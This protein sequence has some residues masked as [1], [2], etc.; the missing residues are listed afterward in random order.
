MKI[1][2]DQAHLF[3][4][5][6]II[7]TVVPP[8]ATLPILSNVLLAAEQEELI[9]SATDLDISISTRVGVEVMEPGGV[10]APA[11]KLLQIVRELPDTKLLLET[12]GDRISLS[13][14]QGHYVL[15]GIPADQ[16]PSLPTDVEGLTVQADAD[17]LRRM[18][19][20]TIFAASTD[21]TNP[22]LNGV[23]WRIED[24]EGV[25]RMT[26]VA[27]DGHRLARIVMDL[28][29]AVGERAEAILP[30][31]VLHQL[32][33][34]ISSGAELKKAIVGESFVVF[35]LGSTVLFSRVIEGPYPDFEQVIPKQ[36]EKKLVASH[37]ILVPAIRRVSILA[38]AETHQVRLSLSENAMKLTSASRDIG[39]E[40][41]EMLQVSY[42]AEDLEIAYDASY[43]I[44]I[45]R[46]MDSEEVVFELDTPVSAGI[47]RPV[48]GEEGQDY[49]CLIMPLRFME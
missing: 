2:T 20:K 39:A 41:R 4:G 12:E 29:E 6:Q 18:I 10:T 36:N 47:I 5:I 30:P 32:V 16:F 46:N 1:S 25:G 24:R 15:T 11:R 43:L 49:L 23:L 37:D 21:E 34:L 19:E 45:L 3:S 42:Q 33:R 35:D 14:D 40:A 7:S 31:K 48:Q 27:T 17:L 22:V 8:R 44:D 13:S 26:M 9:L 28:P 38:D